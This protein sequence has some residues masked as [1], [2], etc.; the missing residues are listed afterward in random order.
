MS[1]GDPDLSRAGRVCQNCTIL[2]LRVAASFSMCSR[3]NLISHAG[4]VLHIVGSTR[5]IPKKNVCYSTDCRSGNMESNGMPG[6]GASEGVDDFVSVEGR[7]GNVS[8]G[9]LHHMWIATSMS[10]SMGKR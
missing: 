2:L 5:S 6:V 3:P 10:M 7:R 8:L 4:N 1:S 9:E